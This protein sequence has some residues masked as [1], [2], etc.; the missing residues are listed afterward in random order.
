MLTSP[1]HLLLQ[2]IRR[3]RAENEA[4]KT[5]YNKLELA[6]LSVLNNM[7]EQNSPLYPVSFAEVKKLMPELKEAHVR[8]V[9]LQEQ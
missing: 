7:L 2:E 4:L 8:A 6:T 3:L 1:S 5:K 9:I